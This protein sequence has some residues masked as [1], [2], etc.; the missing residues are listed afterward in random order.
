MMIKDIQ[1]VEAKYI[2]TENDVTEIA[3]II[4]FTSE[5]ARRTGRKVLVV[6]ELITE[7]PEPI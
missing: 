2:K 3:D 5:T 1:V 7:K 6:V 4:L